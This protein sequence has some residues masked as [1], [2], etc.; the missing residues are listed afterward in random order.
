[1]SWPR[2]WKFQV[3]NNFK[4]YSLIKPLQINPQE[5]R[6][7][8]NGDLLSW[9]SIFRSRN[10]PLPDCATPWQSFD[11]SIN[12]KE[13]TLNTQFCAPSIHYVGSEVSNSSNNTEKEVLKHLPENKNNS[14]SLETWGFDDEEFD[15]IVRKQFCNV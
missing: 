6:K 10:Y 14:S 1:M 12:L 7:R 3:S 9:I 13:N 4:L 2:M 11:E 8:D 15:E 5:Q